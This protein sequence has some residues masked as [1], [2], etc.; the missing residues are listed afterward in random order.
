MSGR[1]LVVVGASAGGVRAVRPLIDD[2]PK[3]LDATLP[4]V[5]HSSTDSS[6]YLAQHLN[7]AGGMP[8]R[9]AVDGEKLVRGRVYVAPR[10]H[11]VLVEPGRARVVL[12]LDRES[13]ADPQTRRACA[14][15]WRRR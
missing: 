4:V 10:D 9:E 7:N 5:V 11:H 6:G 1:D 14:V 15:Q 3:T 2:L 8:A 12:E 13:P